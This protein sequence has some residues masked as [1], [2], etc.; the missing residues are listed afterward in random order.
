MAPSRIRKSEWASKLMAFTG[1]LLQGPF[2]LYYRRNYCDHL[3]LGFLPDLTIKN[4]EKRLCQF[5]PTS[6]LN[7]ERSSISWKSKCSTSSSSQTLTCPRTIIWLP[8]QNDYAV[9]W[10]YLIAVP[11]LKLLLV[12]QKFLSLCLLGSYYNIFSFRIVEKT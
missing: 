2:L 12:S 4:Y 10:Q 11:M 7:L 9:C 6:W 1:F 8:L 3:L 5:F